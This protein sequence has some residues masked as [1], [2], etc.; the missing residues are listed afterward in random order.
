MRELCDELGLSKTAV[1]WH[2]NRL[3]KDG[4]I[5]FVPGEP[6]RTI[7]PTPAGLAKSKKDWKFGVRP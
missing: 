1:R 2:I 6:S 3:A 5:T 4:L 7:V